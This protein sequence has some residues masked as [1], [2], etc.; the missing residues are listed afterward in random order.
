MINILIAICIYI[1][2]PL[3]LFD[4]KTEII[5]VLGLGFGLSTLIS[6]FF[7]KKNVYS[8]NKFKVRGFAGR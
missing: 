6:L 4:T 3:Q 5:L 8:Q 7:K 1:I 2:K